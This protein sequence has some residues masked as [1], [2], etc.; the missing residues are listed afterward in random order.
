MTSIITLDKWIQSDSGQTSGRKDVPGGPHGSVSLTSPSGTPQDIV[1]KAKTG[2]PKDKTVNHTSEGRRTQNKGNNEL[3]ANETG[4]KT[5]N[6]LYK[7]PAEVRL[8]PESFLKQCEDQFPDDS[9][10]MSRVRSFRNGTKEKIKGQWKQIEE[11]REP[12]ILY[13]I[14]QYTNSRKN[15]RKY[16]GGMK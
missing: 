13:Q 14:W 5:E 3:P 2:I 4:R 7:L 16:S 8:H 9:L 10:L 12:Y 11:P 6:Y 15:G 1:K